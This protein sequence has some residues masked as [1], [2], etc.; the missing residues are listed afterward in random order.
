MEIPNN[1]KGGDDYEKNHYK[2]I[3]KVMDSGR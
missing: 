2:K 3:G 1:L